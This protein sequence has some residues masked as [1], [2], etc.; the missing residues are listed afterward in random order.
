MSQYTE[1]IHLYICTPE[2]EY[3]PRPL[4][5]SFRLEELDAK[6][7]VIMNNDV[8]EVDESCSYTE[9]LLMFINQWKKLRPIQRRK[10]LGKPL[11]LPLAVELCYLKE[12]VNHDNLVRVNL[13]D[14]WLTIYIP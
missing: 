12:G 4:F 5:K 3:R 2:S 1:R 10:L 13:Q 7:S 14:M 9:V 6:S 11:Q 8:A